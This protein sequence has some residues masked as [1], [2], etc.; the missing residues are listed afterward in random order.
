[1]NRSAPQQALRKYV[2]AMTCVHL[3]VSTTLACPMLLPEV[4]RQKGEANRAIERNLTAALAKS[5]DAVYV[6]VAQAVD[7][8]AETATFLV[9]RALKGHAPSSSRVTISFPLGRLGMGCSGAERFERVAAVIGQRHVMFQ[10]DGRS[11]RVSSEERG[12]DSVSFDEEVSIVLA[13]VATQ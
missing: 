4:Q 10:R 7:R 6:A 5:A 13:T 3:F 11:V 9:Q 8:R 2:V 1:V 12:S